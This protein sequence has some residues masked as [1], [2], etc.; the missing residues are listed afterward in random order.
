M[1]INI[2]TREFPPPHVLVSSHCLSLGISSRQIQSP[3]HHLA[4]GYIVSRRVA[5]LASSPSNRTSP[6]ISGW[7]GRGGEE[8]ED[9]CLACIIASRTACFYCSSGPPLRPCSLRRAFSQVFTCGCLLASLFFFFW[10]WLLVA[11]CPLFLL[12]NCLLMSFGDLSCQESLI[13]TPRIRTVH[14]IAPSSIFSLGKEE[15]RGT[16]KDLQQLQV[17]GQA[18]FLVLS[19]P[20]RSQSCVQPPSLVANS[21]ISFS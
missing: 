21:D 4:G 5:L 7:R 18:L 11:V 10:W 12:L 8:G 13:S 16:A 17:C 14:I 6:G 15:A 19:T 2:Y 20:W 3:S 9:R 1:Y